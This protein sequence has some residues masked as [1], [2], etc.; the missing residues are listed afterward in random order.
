MPPWH[1][2]HG[3][4]RQIPPLEF[5]RF[6]LYIGCEYVRQKGSHK[7]FHR[8]GLNRPIIIPFHG[9]DLPVFVVRNTLRQLNIPL[10]DYLEILVRI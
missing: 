9:G 7:V 6:L 4:L 3:K 2:L 10:N 8:T 1:N 5:E